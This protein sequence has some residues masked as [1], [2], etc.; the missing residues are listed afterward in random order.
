MHINL[1]NIGP[2]VKS[3]SDGIGEMLQK[4]ERAFAG[5]TESD[6]RNRLSEEAFLEID[7]LSPRKKLLVNIVNRHFK[8]AIVGEF[9]SLSDN[10][11]AMKFRTSKGLMTCMVIPSLT[12]S[13][14]SMRQ[15]MQLGDWAKGDLVITLGKRVVLEMRGSYL[16]Q[17]FHNAIMEGLEFNIPI[18]R[19]T[20][21]GNI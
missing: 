17:N 19:H 14:R 4:A 1:K 16:A 11:Y 12:E 15:R 7:S 5:P 13:P 21:N 20:F 8:S 10:G 3:L 18:E 6:V 9:Q 2:A